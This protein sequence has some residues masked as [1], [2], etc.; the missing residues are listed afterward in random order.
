M[1]IPEM[2]RS[3]QFRVN[4]ELGTPLKYLKALFVKPFAGLFHAFGSIKEPKRYNP[5]LNAG[6]AKGFRPMNEPTYQ[7]KEQPDA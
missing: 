5:K 3:S 4:W 1:N 2:V 6:A 7:A